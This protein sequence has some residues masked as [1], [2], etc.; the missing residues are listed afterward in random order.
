MRVFARIEDGVVR[1]LHWAEAD[2]SGRFHAA[3]RWVEV[4]GR[5]VKEGFR[6]TEAGFVAPVEEAVE[7]VMEPTIGELQAAVAELGARI[8]AM[9]L[10]T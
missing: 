8:A 2:I 5:D 4:T 7:A 6:E 1:E 3:L 9:Q 10:R